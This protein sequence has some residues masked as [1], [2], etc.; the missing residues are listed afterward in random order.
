MEIPL[1]KKSG[2]EKDFHL[3]SLQIQ[4]DALIR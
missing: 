3:V 2:M 1:S 4:L